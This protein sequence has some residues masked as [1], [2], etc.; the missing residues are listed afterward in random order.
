M[1]ADA[2]AHLILDVTPMLERKTAAAMCHRTQHALFVRRRSEEAGRKLEV[3]EVIMAQESVTHVWPP[4]NGSAPDDRF[5]Q[6]LLS[7]GWARRP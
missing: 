7:S 2:P 1:N 6:A 4:M 5:S 3:P